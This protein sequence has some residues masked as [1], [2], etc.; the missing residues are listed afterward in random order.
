M[1]TDIKNYYE[2]LD[3]ET[4]ASSKDIENAYRRSLS[5][6]AED[7]NAI[8]SILSDQDSSQM[9]QLIEEAYII[10][11]SE[12]NRKQYDEKR[13]INRF[14]E[15]E[16]SSEKKKVQ[17]REEI[18]KGKYELDYKINHEFEQ[19][20]ENCSE[21]TGEFL[22]QIRE[23][24]NVSLSRLSEMTKI[25]TPYLVHLEAENFEKLPAT[26]Y[27]RGFVFQ[28]AKY[29]K[30]NPDLV[31]SSYISKVKEKRMEISLH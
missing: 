19:K 17:S 7:S 29:L 31:S 11:S 15:N 1:N 9:R 5:L 18:T 16:Q 12:E 23:Y 4:H 2:V 3:I 25:M 26:A 10:L 24:K 8:Y 28:Y 6:Y 21:F 13:G 22:K 14:L 20:I 27:V 30:L